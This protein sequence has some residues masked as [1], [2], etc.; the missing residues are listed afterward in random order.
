MK[1]KLADCTLREIAEMCHKY[2]WGDG[3]C[4]Q[5]PFSEHNDC[6]FD[7]YPLCRV[8]EKAEQIEVEVE[9]PFTEVYKKHLRQEELQVARKLKASGYKY[10]RRVGEKGK[11]GI[12]ANRDGKEIKLKNQ[13][14]F[15]WVKKY[16]PID[17]I[18]KKG[19]ITK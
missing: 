11:E 18:L 12:Y 10:I 6:M 13:D 5:C 1:K 9:S 4:A 19:G 16:I 2:L 7:L 14:L 15:Q 17:E 3:R 8:G